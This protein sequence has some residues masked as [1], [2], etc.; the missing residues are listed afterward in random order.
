MSTEFKVNDRVKAFGCE[1]VVLEISNK[2]HLE[3]HVR[4]ESNDGAKHMFF[5]SQGKLM[6]WHKEPSLVLVE[7]AKTKVKLYPVL[8]TLNDGVNYY[9]SDILFDSEAKAKKYFGEAF[10]RLL[11][12][13]HHAV[14][15]EE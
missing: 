2:L 10:I 9:M 14:E 15:V 7:R 5:T 12:D 6:V 8:H 4:L 1:G 13:D 11:T 3:V